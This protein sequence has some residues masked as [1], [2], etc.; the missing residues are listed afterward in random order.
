MLLIITAINMLPKV[1]IK[2]VLAMFLLLHTKCCMLW[3][4]IEFVQTQYILQILFITLMLVH[5][6]VLRLLGFPIFWVENHRKYYRSSL[7][8]F[9]FGKGVK[10][11][12]LLLLYREEVIHG[13]VLLLL[14]F[15][16]NRYKPQI[17]FYQCQID[18]R[19][20]EVNYQACNA[21]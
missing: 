13:Q 1:V 20:I 12:C 21:Y 3:W 8:S 7:L 14:D 19:G 6:A 9:T 17:D 10:I 16:L 18:L 11:T 15:K 5:S 2:A 4:F